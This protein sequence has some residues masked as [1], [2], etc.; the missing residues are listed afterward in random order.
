MNI[1]IAG[2]L[3]VLFAIFSWAVGFVILWFIIRTAVLSALTS[4][5]NNEA[6]RRES[7]ALSQRV[8]ERDAELELAKEQAR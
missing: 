7:E 4:H 2:P 6:V 5:S 1:D 8:R 3:A